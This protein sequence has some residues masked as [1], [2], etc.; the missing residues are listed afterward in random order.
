MQNDVVVGTFGETFKDGASA[1][2][3]YILVQ[4][5]QFGPTDVGFVVNI[6][7]RKTVLKKF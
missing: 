7:N 6:S 4:A 1:S 2:P 5:I 3:A